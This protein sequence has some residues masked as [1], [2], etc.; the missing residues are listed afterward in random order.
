MVNLYYF[1]AN[2]NQLKYKLKYTDKF[3]YHTTCSK[4][5]CKKVAKIYGDLGSHP[6]ITQLFG[7]HKTTLTIE[8]GESLDERVFNTLAE[9]KTSFKEILKAFN[10][11]HKK[12]M[13]HA[14]ISKHCVY[15]LGYNGHQTTKIGNLQHCQKVKDDDEVVNGATNNFDSEHLEN[16]VRRSQIK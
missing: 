5:Q 14:N 4:Q 12:G 9:L 11:I 10:W 1:Q 2:M 8:H 16:Y 13:V 15:L 7:V 3:V 6:H